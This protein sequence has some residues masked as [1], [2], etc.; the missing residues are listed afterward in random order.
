MNLFQCQWGES[1]ESRIY[2]A[3]REG[4]LAGEGCKTS[5]AA[6]RRG[7]NQQDNLEIFLEY[8]P[9]SGFTRILYLDCK[10]DV[11]AEKP[12]T[13]VRFSV[14]LNL[15]FTEM[16]DDKIHTDYGGNFT[17]GVNIFRRKEFV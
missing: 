8:Y 17:L 2:L 3:Y 12:R 14:K 13:G 10:E 7:A 15:T 11:E 9:A 1:S 6:T 4:R 16:T 5:N